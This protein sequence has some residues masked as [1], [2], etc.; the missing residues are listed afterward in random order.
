MTTSKDQ[1]DNKLKVA[2]PYPDYARRISQG[3]TANNK[4]QPTIKN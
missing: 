1:L 3:Q 4:S 2:N